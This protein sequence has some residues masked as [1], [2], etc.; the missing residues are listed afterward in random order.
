MTDE[1]Q[2]LIF[3]LTL[4][5]DQRMNRETMQRFATVEIRPLA[6][7]VDAG[8]SPA[9]DFYPKTVELGICAA[10]YSRSPGRRGCRPLTFLQRV[11]LWKISHTVIYLWP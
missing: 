10:T 2:D 7:I 8:D 6:K 4:T 9:Q 3:D 1:T 11:D 5:D